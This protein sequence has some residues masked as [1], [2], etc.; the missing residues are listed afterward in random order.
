MNALALTYTPE[1]L[2]YMVE[3]GDTKMCGKTPQQAFTLMLLA[4]AKGLHP[5]T[6]LLDYD[7][8]SGR[9]SKTSKAIIRDFLAAGGKVEWHEFTDKKCD[10]TFSH[11]SGGTIRIDWDMERAAR[12][13]LLRNDMYK[14]YPRNMLKARCISDGVGMVYAEAMDGMYTPEETADFEPMPIDQPLQITEIQEE[15]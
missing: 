8:I 2:L 6:A 5:I 15:F 1:S 9:P 4:Q 12:A 3:H 11:P 10:A 7:I 14:K 13:G